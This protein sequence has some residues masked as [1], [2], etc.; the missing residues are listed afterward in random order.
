MIGDLGEGNV[1][2]QS[3]S[4]TSPD[5]VFGKKPVLTICKSVTTMT[6]GTNSQIPP[7]PKGCK[8]KVW[9]DG[10]YPSMFG[11]P[12]QRWSCR[13]CGYKFSDPKDLE[14]AKKALQD[15]ES[16][17]SMKLKSPNDIDSDCQICVKETKNLVADQTTTL[18]IP[19]KHEKQDQKGAVIEFL[20]YLQKQGRAQGTYTPYCYNLE[21]LI[22]NG[23]NL[24]DPE[25]VKT[26]LTNT[27]SSKS[28][29][30]KYNLV[31]AYKAFMAAYGIK[32]HPAQF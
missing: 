21:F 30:R 27:L 31:K 22:N 18:V 12:I 13:E 20:F 2:L 19:Q 29:A 8:G 17:E 28:N 24:F 10:H 5:G 4:E 23:A 16:I 26:T 14:R 6:A 1:G 9:R 7:C 3:D 32:Y 15:L 25:S 11:Y